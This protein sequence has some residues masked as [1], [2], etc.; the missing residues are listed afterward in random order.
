MTFTFISVAVCVLGGGH[1]L[2]RAHG[3]LLS[4]SFH[5]S[6][7]EGLNSGSDLRS[8]SHS[9]NLL[10]GLNLELLI[11]LPLHPPVLSLQVFTTKPG[12]TRC[13]GWN[14]G[15][16]ACWTSLLPAELHPQPKCSYGGDG[17]L[18]SQR[19]NVLPKVT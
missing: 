10:T 13:Q 11:L 12:L 9:V 4:L 8:K 6:V 3:G 7:F 19:F 1:V 5:L 14:P 2:E 18:E 16:H 17:E 15:L